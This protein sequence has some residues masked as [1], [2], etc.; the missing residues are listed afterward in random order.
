MSII[1]KK[2]GI[3]FLFDTIIFDTK[4]L[5][6]QKV[7]VGQKKEEKEIKFHLGPWDK[8]SILGQPLRIVTSPAYS[9]INIYE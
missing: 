9:K 8:D 1:N 7:T 4:H 2:P 5:S 6:I 3:D